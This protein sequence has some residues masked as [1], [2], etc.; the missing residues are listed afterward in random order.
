M[1]SSNK[2]VMSNNTLGRNGRNRHRGNGGM[3]SS[4]S[5]TSCNSCNDGVRNEIYHSEGQ[6]RIVLNNGNFKFITIFKI[7]VHDVTRA[8]NHEIDF[9]IAQF[10]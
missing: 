10:R 3:T 5:A 4:S 2:K 9:H 8:N 6:Q 7:L 1:Y